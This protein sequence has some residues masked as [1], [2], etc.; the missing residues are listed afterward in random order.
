MAFMLADDQQVSVAFT[1]VDR[2]GNPARLDGAPVWSSSD[3]LILTVTPNDDNSA[4]VLAVGPTG[5]AQVQVT[6]DADI[7]S[8]IRN[9]VGILDVEVVAGE[10]VSLDLVPGTPTTQPI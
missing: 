9:L 10:A 5:T 7:G 2:R 8:G 6:V 3:P 1:A 4:A